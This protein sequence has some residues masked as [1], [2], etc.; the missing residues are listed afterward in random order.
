MRHDRPSDTARFVLN[1][2]YWAS[3]HPHLRSEVPGGLARYTAEMIRCLEWPG[4]PDGSW[5]Q[6]RSLLWKTGLIQAVSIPGIYLHQML[7]KRFIESIS[8]S[9][10][11]NSVSQVVVFGAG[12]DTLSLRIASSHPGMTVIEVDHPATQASKK[13][14]VGRFDMPTGRC[15]FVESDLERDGV[16]GAL[17]HCPEY[18]PSASTLFI[19]EGL[20]MYLGEPRVRDLLE[21]VGESPR[22]SRILF[23]YM[24]ETPSGRWDFAEQRLIVTKWLSFRNERFTWGTRPERI[25][26]FVADCGLDLIAH[27]TTEDLRVEML[28]ESNRGA[29]LAHGEN[30]VLA[31]PAC[32]GD[33]GHHH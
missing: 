12:Y 25:P 17:E 1:G 8:R 2:I 27:R 10:V 24:E 20:T 11:L 15:V 16:T 6:R 7:R 31:A 19:A 3:R 21:F 18:D 5:L 9:D 29:R 32:L 33:S 22:D 30:I 13:A 14:A 4:R 26:G 28:Q 23:T